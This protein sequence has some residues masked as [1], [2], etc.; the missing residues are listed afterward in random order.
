LATRQASVSGQG[1]QVPPQSM[2]VSLSFLMPSEQWAGRLEPPLPPVPPP[3]LP[4]LPPLPEVL[5]DA[6]EELLACELDE[7]LL[8][9]GPPPAPPEPPVPPAS[10][11]AWLWVSL[12]EHPPESAMAEQPIERAAT[13]NEPSERIVDK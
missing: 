12:L 5:D 11:G 2:S 8:V 7:L 13:N 1:A 9:A 6:C 4:P 3:A 10:G